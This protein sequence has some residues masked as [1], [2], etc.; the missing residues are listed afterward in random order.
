MN[1]ATIEV[2]V[3]EDDILAQMVAKFILQDFNCRVDIAKSEN[4][5]L[6]KANIIKY[7]LIF[8]DLGLG[9]SDGFTVIKKIKEHSKNMNTPIFIL[10]AHRTIDLQQKAASVGIDEFI[11]K[12]LEKEKVVE[13]INKYVAK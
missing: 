3:V 9:K 13:I 7:Q 1:K 8:I 5:A 12:P 4:E 10:T 11:T 2:L 6:G